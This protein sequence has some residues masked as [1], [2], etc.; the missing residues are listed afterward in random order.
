MTQLSRDNRLLT[1]ALVLWGAG[2]GLFLYIQTLY[3]QELG[4]KPEE[5]GG[6]LALAELAA[7]LSHIPAGYL[8]DRLGRKQIL[9]A[10]WAVG[11]IAVWLMYLAPS[12]WVFVLALMLYRFTG[13][14]LA[15]INAYVSEARG[16]QS[17]QRA[18]TLVSASFWAGTLFS[19]A[20]GGWVGATY[21]LRTVYGIAGIFF[22]VS[23]AA[24]VFLRPQPLTPPTHGEARYTALFRNRRFAGFLLLMFVVML[25]IQ[26][27]L[28][29]GPN[30]VEDAREQDVQVVGLLGSVTSMGIV[31]VNV[32]FGQR[33]PRRGFMLAQVLLAVSLLVLLSTTSLPAL[34]V[35]FGLRAGWSLARNMGNAQVR[36]VVTTAESGLAFGVFETVYSATIILG[37]LIAGQLYARSFALP[38][39]VSLICIL[40]TLPLVWRFAPRRDEQ[41]EEAPAVMASES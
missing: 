2:E 9:M 17:V 13:F 28:P 23:T 38:F 39:Q 24:L 3:L 32:V 15:P 14:V 10:G 27:G 1:L 35:V 7:S 37:S 18:I 20:V 33:L 31:L 26:I 40:L 5:I 36:R 29:F 6:A 19:P 12:L 30:F 16:A 41:S 25:A 11:V 8:S 21:G 34:T 4:A 22:V